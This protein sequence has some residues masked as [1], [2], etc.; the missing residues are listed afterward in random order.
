MAYTQYK[1]PV[2]PAYYS[3]DFGHTPRIPFIPELVYTPYHPEPRPLPPGPPVRSFAQISGDDPSYQ[4]PY[5]QQAQG[6]RRC[7]KK[8]HQC[9]NSH[10]C[11]QSV[12]SPFCIIPWINGDNPNPNFVF[13]LSLT[14]YIPYYWKN[15]LQMGIP[16]SDLRDPATVPFVSRMRIMIDEMPQWPCDI[17]FEPSPSGVEPP[18]TLRDILRWLH[19]HMHKRI[20]ESDWNQLSRDRQAA[21]SWWFRNRCRS[22]VYH[23]H[24]ERAKGAK[25]V[26]FLLGKTRLVGLKYIG[27]SEDGWEIMKL[28][29]HYVPT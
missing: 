4:D 22:G 28:V 17:W 26:D 20:A 23:Y 21:V 7:R 1:K 19:I 10:C 18:V 14:D 13:D 16:Y 24:D 8:K 9:H 29:T 11:I 6:P 25:R 2:T 5:H 3:R 15:G 27:Y 12:T